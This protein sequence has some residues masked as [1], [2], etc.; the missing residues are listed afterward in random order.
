MLERLRKMIGGGATPPPDT[1]ASAAKSAPVAHH[2]ALPV[3]T[4]D[5]VAW[6]REHGI[7]LGR[8]DTGRALTLS[9]VDGQTA[10]RG[11][12]GASNRDFIHGAELR[13]RAELGLDPGV[14]VLV[15]N[16]PLRA[17]L[18]R[19]AYS[20]FTDS[21]Q[22]SVDSSLTE[23]L[24]WLAMYE[25]KGWADLPDA[26]VERYAILARDAGEAR[27]YVSDELIACMTGW[28]SPPMTAEHALMLIVQRGKAYLRM[29][30]LPEPIE[31][32][33]H[34]LRTHA[35]LCR[36]ARAAAAKPDLSL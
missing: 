18:E 17:A 16:R 12:I 30:Y 34:A 22:T 9:G 10:W 21:L 1:A 19:L 28:P 24:R 36:A 4:P 3:V 13:L 35:V 15:I 5:L 11:E 29:E 8:S 20:Q 27:A 26:F 33:Q 31:V 2:A 32:L 23:E 7:F 6:T 25:E 14:F